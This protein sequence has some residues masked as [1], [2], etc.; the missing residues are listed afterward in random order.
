LL[1]WSW[2]YL[3]LEIRFETAVGRFL[4]RSDVSEEGEQPPLEDRRLSRE[5]LAEMACE[6]RC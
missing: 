3:W 6:M 1:I 5:T 4:V 2:L